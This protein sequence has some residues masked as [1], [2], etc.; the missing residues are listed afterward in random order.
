MH[1]RDQDLEM[2]GVL[3]RKG[4]EA[5]DC[6]KLTQASYLYSRLRCGAIENE[7]VLNELGDAITEGFA[8]CRAREI[9]VPAKPL[10]P[11]DAD[12]REAIV[13]E[14]AAAQGK[15][16]PQ[17]RASYEEARALLRFGGVDVTRSDIRLLLALGRARA[18]DHSLTPPILE[19]DG[20]PKEFSTA[21]EVLA[22]IEAT[23][24]KARDRDDW[25]KTQRE[26]L[27]ARRWADVDFE[28]LSEVIRDG[29]H[30]GTPEECEVRKQDTIDF[31]VRWHW[32]RSFSD[33]AKREL[34]TCVRAFYE[35]LGGDDDADAEVF[36]S[37]SSE[38]MSDSDQGVEQLR[39]LISNATEAADRDALIKLSNVWDTL[40][41]RA[42]AN[43][44]DSVFEPLREALNEGFKACDVRESQESPKRLPEELLSP[45]LDITMRK[46]IIRELAV[47]HG[48]LVKAPPRSRASYEEAC[49]LLCAVGVKVSTSDLRLL[50]AAGR[51]RALVDG[52]AGRHEL[53]PTSSTEEAWADPDEMHDE[54][55]KTEAWALAQR[56]A[57]AGRRTADL[58]VDGLLALLADGMRPVLTR[59][60]VEEQAQDWINFVV[61]SEWDRITSKELRRQLALGLTAF[62]GDD[63]RDDAIT[64]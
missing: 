21:A 41:T 18:R 61:R 12:I 23:N 9:Q 56:Q 48:D 45:E 5:A 30:A 55:A 15:R 53:L 62:Y 46:A 13:H 4:A 20:Q 58:D 11:L 10:I 25:A 34:A 17:A 8:T 63:Y 42:G 6:G 51:H 59:E 37:G 16:P 57:L 38:G 22:D 29:A 47:A 27:E 60:D 43:E 40:W 52:V 64:A 14:L 31:A 50:L 36:H 44:D 39:V 32:N 3:I 28:R 1:D 7:P 24:R 19:V 2:L 54:S 26:A 49:A 33:E 35:F